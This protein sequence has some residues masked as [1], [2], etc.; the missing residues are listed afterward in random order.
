MVMVVHGF[1]SGTG[2][3]VRGDVVFESAGGGSGGGP[4]NLRART[5]NAA[6]LPKSPPTAG[7]DI[8][9]EPVIGWKLKSDIWIA[10]RCVLMQLRINDAASLQLRWKN[11]KLKLVQSH[12]MD[13]KLKLIQD[14][15]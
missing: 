11:G 8:R 4:Q 7:S 10:A 3:L 2:G 12:P 9:V 1:G 15:P 13:G 5:L 14:S 6:H